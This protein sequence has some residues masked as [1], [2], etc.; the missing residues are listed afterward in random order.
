[1]TKPVSYS[2][3]MASRRERL[4]HPSGPELEFLRIMGCSVIPLPFSKQRSTGKP[5]VL[6]IMRGVMRREHMEREVLVGGYCI[7]FGNDIRR[8][9]EVDGEHWHKDV[10]KEQERDDHLAKY[11]WIILHIP[12]RR[13]YQEPGRVIRDVAEFLTK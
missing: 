10:V 4:L 12:E 11:G 1:M 3:K 9:I 13:L 7:D 6:V 8:G 5:G 2:Q